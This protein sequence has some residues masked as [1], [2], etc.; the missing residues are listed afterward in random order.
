MNIL[1]LHTHDT[2]RYI[3]PYGYTVPTP[4]LM[5]FASKGTLF[6]QAFCA[7]PTCSPSRAALLTGMSPHSC[8]MTGLAH[9]GFQLNDYSKHLAAF[10]GR[11]DY[12]TVLCGVQHEAP[13]DEMIGY[14]KIISADPDDGFSTWDETNA[15]N[16]AE[17]I[18]KENNQPF[19]LSLGLHHTHR[20]FPDID[21]GINPDYIQ[22]PMPLYDT[23]ECREDMAAF[24]T[25]AMIADCYIGRVLDALRQSGKEDDTLIIFTT[26]HGI[27]FPQMKCNLYDAGIG[28]SLIIKYPGNPL[29]GKAVDTLVSQL[30]I[31][32]TLCDL[33]QTEKPD[34]LQ[35]CSL[36]PLFKGKSDQIREEIFSEVNYH[37]AYEPMRC[38]R[39]QRYKLIRFYD[40]H[41]RYIP[42]NIDGS[43]SKNF[44]IN[45]G[46]LEQKRDR[47]MLF[48]LYL[49]PVERVNLIDD[50][51]YKAVYADLSKRL[52]DWQLATDD[53]ILNGVVPKPVGANINSFLPSSPGNGKDYFNNK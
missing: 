20:R 48:D 3:Q 15:Q 2:G 1:Y 13:E 7:G 14:K 39:T 44:V 33:I 46:F 30:D 11:M 36:L 5:S 18:M 38:I 53:P 21:P 28:V 26:D 8:G 43:P 47:E 6:R 51:K 35:G 25:S 4:N 31:Y 45:Y 32:P 22:P 12:E 16:A 52:K 41:D 24:M 34:W 49:D 40:E 42:D 19:F 10:L 27:A 50:E 23:K 37:A 9:R 17:Y 29:K